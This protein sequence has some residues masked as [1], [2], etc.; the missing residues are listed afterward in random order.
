MVHIHQGYVTEADGMATMHTEVDINGEIQDVTISVESQ[1]GKFLSPERA[2]YALIG[3]I[4]RSMKRHDPELICDAP[5]TEDLLYNIREILIP[6]LCNSDSR[7]FPV[8]IQADIAPALDKLPFAKNSHGGVGT[9]ISCGVDSFYSILKHY[10]SDYP[11][12]KLTHL[13]MLDVGNFQNGSYKSRDQAVKEKTLE[14]SEKVSEELNL[15]LL[16]I[17]SNFQIVIPLGNL[18]FHTYRSVMAVYALQKLFRT[19]YYGSGYSFSDFVLNGNFALDPAYFD[20]LLLDCFSTENLRLYSSGGECDRN[21]KV[22]FIADNPL[23]QKYLH[24]CAV[25]EKNCGRCEKCIRTLL[26]LDAANR[27][28]DFRQSFDIDDYFKIR[29]YIYIYLQ[30][31][32]RIPKNAPY[33]EK[34]YKILYERHKEFF[35]SITP[36]TKRIFKAR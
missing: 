27:L 10:D 1:Y 17:E 34:S 9:G 31:K 22:E 8:K 23:A 19:Y 32:V 6:S 7:M 5:V 26:A 29:D 16:K 25:K 15:P 28:E 35:D 2:D 3:L 30:D 14:R 20:L 4:V 24:A 11:S 33:Y 36:E 18:N 12:K 13:V 21:D